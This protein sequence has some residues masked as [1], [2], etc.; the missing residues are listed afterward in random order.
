MEDYPARV[1]MQDLQ[2]MK[3][4][5]NHMRNP[6]ILLVA[7]L[8]LAP[9]FVDAQSL[10]S[11]TTL[12]AAVNSDVTTIQVASATNILTPGLYQSQ[13]GL[14]SVTG[15]PNVETLYVDRELMKVNSISGVYISVERGYAGTRSSG[16][17]NAATVTIAAASLFTDYDHFGSC[18][19]ALLPYLPLLNTN[20]GNWYNCPSSG[21]D[22]GMWVVSTSG[23]TYHT[24][25][26]S[27]EVAPTAC[28]TSVSGNSTGTQGY[29]TVGASATPVVQA[30]TSGTGTNTHTY[31][32]TISA[33]ERLTAGRG[34][35]IT[36]IDFFYGVQTNA[37][38]TQAATL[39]SGTLNSSIVFS[40]ITYPVAAASETASTVTPVRLDAGT[41][42]LTPAV[43]SFNTATT[44]AGAF[45][46]ESATPATPIAVSTDLRQFLFTVT[47]QCTASTA[48][49]TNSPG[50]R[51]YYNNTQ[52]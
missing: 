52:F 43:A 18:T 42:L 34:S 39:A 14:G 38:G 19:A 4:K 29:T 16:H 41:M 23:Q 15:G 28:Y 6:K 40:S 31:I 12:A 51:V 22:S 17:N 36:K 37:L 7:A 25:D 1:R 32:C 45:Y 47:L 30:D 44:T 46:T 8:L 27:F 24:Q 21:V 49:I 2:L 9:A 50:L 10:Y 26:N 13:G 5:T 33:P 48:T 3:G 11:T 35:E 20:D